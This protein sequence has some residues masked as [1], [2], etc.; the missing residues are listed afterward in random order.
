M[1]GPTV[2]WY[3]RPS[4]REV[5]RPG[6]R[7]A[8]SLPAASVVA[9]LG[10]VTSVK[11][12]E[13]GP[14]V[15]DVALLAAQ[16]V[17]L[18]QAPVAAG[19]AGTV[20]QDDVY[21]LVGRARH[22]EPEREEAADRGFP[23]SAPQSPRGRRSE[24]WSGTSPWGQAGAGAAR[25][26]GEPR[27]QDLGAKLDTQPVRVPEPVAAG[28][29]SPV[30]EDRVLRGEVEVVDTRPLPARAEEGEASPGQNHPHRIR[31]AGSLP[32]LASM[33]LLLSGP[34]LNVPPGSTVTLPARR[35]VRRLEGA[36]QEWARDS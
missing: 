4:A 6:P 27:S 18:S 28:E 8:A 2:I 1:R 15:Q 7:G 30:H 3:L 36:G 19:V 5:A 23:P 11:Q 10:P 24:E 32:A 34:V 12:Q 13:P 26:G 20:A 17:R 35:Q 9:P 25:S 21:V 33:A 14:D 31:R 16:H 29:A 22:G